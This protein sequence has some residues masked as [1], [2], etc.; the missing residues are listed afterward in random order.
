[1]NPAPP[2]TKMFF[3]S[4]N[5]SNFVVPIRTGAWVQTSSVTYDRGFKIVEF[6]LSVRSVRRRGHGRY[7]GLD[8]GKMI[9]S[10]QQMTY[11]S[12][13]RGSERGSKFPPRQK[14]DS[15]GQT[16]HKGLNNWES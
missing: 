10:S 16:L 13:K 6:L 7:C 4:G 3:A 5:G 1:M 2:V 8:E 9:Y 15:E 11:F 12:K 14:L